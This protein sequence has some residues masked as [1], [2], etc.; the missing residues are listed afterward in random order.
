MISSIQIEFL[1]IIIRMRLT[2]GNHCVYN[3]SYHIVL[4][5]KYRGFYFKFKIR[6]LIDKYLKLKCDNLNIKLEK[7]EIMPDHIHLFV[8]SSPSISIEKIVSEL[9]GYISFEVRKAIPSIQKY[10]SFWSKGYFVETIGF[11]SEETV[12]KY[13]ANQWVNQK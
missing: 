6:H 7:Y 5:S 8:K 2:S 3:I 10:K 1:L 9:K 4:V 12:K 11:I 13:I